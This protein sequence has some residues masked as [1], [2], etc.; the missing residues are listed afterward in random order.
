L[1]EVNNMS[2]TQ[3]IN[4]LVSKDH[5]GHQILVGLWIEHEGSPSWLEHH[6][7]LFVLDPY[8]QPDVAFLI[9]LAMFLV[10]MLHIYER[11]DS[12]VVLPLVTIRP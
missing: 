10:Q 1:K 5:I 3:N 8:P 2:I 7:R 6:I 11:F 12:E 9:G 4:D